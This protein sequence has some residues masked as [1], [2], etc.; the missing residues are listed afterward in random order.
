MSDGYEVDG[1]TITPLGGGFYTLAH[2]S[3]ADPVRERGKEAAD[4]RAA[5]IAKDAAK[6]DDE[7]SLQPN[8]DTIPTAPPVIEP[9]V[10]EPPVAQAPP[11]P[12]PPPADPAA[13]TIAALLARIEGL[14]KA[15]VATV[16]AVD[17]PTESA[18]PASIPRQYNGQ[19]EA[20]TK[21]AL[22]KMGI[23][24]TKIVLEENESIPPTGLFLGHNG[25]GY[26]IA[27]GEEVDVPDFL[28][29]ILDDAV[30]SA[31]IVD[32]KTQKVLGYRNRSKYPYRRV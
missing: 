32:G 6:G 29:G 20:S 27:P 28:I 9:P 21:A 8:P 10:I 15:A 18:I 3:L 31:P 26:M 17:P 13:A 14:E 11:A 12:T 4:A 1:V 30:M 5:Q 22:K 16:V 7:G 23:G 2:P 24:V 25:R 19:M